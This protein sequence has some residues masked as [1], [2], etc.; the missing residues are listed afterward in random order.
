MKDDAGNLA[1]TM[2][3][4]DIYRQC[5]LFCNSPA[6]A[7][8]RTSLSGCISNQASYQKH[9]IVVDFLRSL[10]YSAVRSRERTEADVEEAEIVLSRL[11]G[12]GLDDEQGD[13]DAADLVMLVRQWV[14]PQRLKSWRTQAYENSCA[15]YVDAKAFEEYETADTVDNLFGNGR[16]ANLPRTLGPTREVGLQERCERPTHIRRCIHSY[17]RSVG[18]VDG[19][20]HVHGPPGMR[21]C[22]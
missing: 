8:A 13:L 18:C 12:F 1:S 6:A 9:Q 14:R 10:G 21:T 4:S 5:T 19:G 11:L 2:S 3:D 20:V 15:E 16:C 22:E 17:S 7:S